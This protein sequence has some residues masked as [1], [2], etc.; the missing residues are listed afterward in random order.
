MNALTKNILLIVIE[1]KPEV[2]S[3]EFSVSSE[4]IN[5]KKMKL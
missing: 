5:K 2:K 3:Q 1:I 4:T